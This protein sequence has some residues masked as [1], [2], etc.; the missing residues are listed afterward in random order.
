M[1]AIV[2]TR[3]GPPEVLQPAEV[4][5]PTPT[6]DQVLV[7]VRA[8]SLNPAEWHMRQGMLLARLFSRSLL[9]PK[10]PIPGADFA[11]QVEAVGRHITQFRPGDEIFGRRGAGGLA[12]YVCVGEKFSAPKPATLTFEQAAAIPV[13]GCTALQSLRDAGRVQPGQKVL[14]NGASGGVGTFTIQ[15]ARVLGAEV[16]GVCST[17]NV[18]LVRSLGADHVIDYTR[19]DFA[20]AGQQYDLIID[21]VG[22]RS[23]LDC[24]RVLRPNGI[25]VGIG[26]WSLARM[27]QGAVLGPL[28]SR[29]QHKTFR[30]MLAHITPADLVWLA[31]RVAAGEVVPVI[32][33]CYPFEQVPEAYRYAEAG[34][35]RGK[36]VV[37]L[38]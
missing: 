3:Y 22:N 18:E 5:K 36:V 31:D 15:I 14:V 19:E 33:R 21:N 32:D 35:A 4:E 8:V 23:V 9:R 25:C 37:T 10:N 16:T 12:E 26:Y 29:T 13:A 34:H 6:D 2:A 17:R 38:A 28:V 1:K 24:A 11:G 20:R 27:L 30:G 7:R